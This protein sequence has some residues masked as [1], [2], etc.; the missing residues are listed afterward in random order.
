MTITGSMYAVVIIALE[1]ER[2]ILHPLK[3]R[4]RSSEINHCIFVYLYFYLSVSSSL[5]PELQ[6]CANRA[7]QLVLIFGKSTRKTANFWENHAKNC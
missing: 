3:V 2:A 1:R 7:N 6:K 4:T 5:C